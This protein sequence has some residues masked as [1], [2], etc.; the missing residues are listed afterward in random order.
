MSLA[1]HV[2]FLFS[3]LRSLKGNWCCLFIIQRLN[4]TAIKICHS[5]SLM[6]VLFHYH[7]SREGSQI[8]QLQALLFFPLPVSCFSLWIFNKPI[9]NCLF[10]VPLFHALHLWMILVQ[11]LACIKYTWPSQD[12]SWD[13]LSRGEEDTSAVPFVSQLDHHEIMLISQ[14][15][16]RS[17]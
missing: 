5:L 4:G 13:P 6:I 3:P 9:S 10:L 14:K 15:L 16:Y 8:S 2:P 17:W 1:C 11:V 7:P 12:K